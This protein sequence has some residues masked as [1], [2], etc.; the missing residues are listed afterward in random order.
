MLRKSGRFPHLAATLEGGDTPLTKSEAI[1]VSPEA[2]ATISGVRP[3]T[4]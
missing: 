4:G 1:F 2:Q 3:G